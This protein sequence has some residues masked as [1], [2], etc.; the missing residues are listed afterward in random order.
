MAYICM[1][2]RVDG[3]LYG[4]VIQVGCALRNG[5]AEVFLFLRS[6]LLHQRLVVIYTARV[7]TNCLHGE[8]CFLGKL[9][10]C[11]LQ[12]ERD[13]FTD[14]SRHSSTLPLLDSNHDM[15]GTTLLCLGN[16]MLVL[17]PTARP[18]SLWRGH[19]KSP[20]LVWVLAQAL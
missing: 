7:W 9:F 18:E 20:L 17:Y 10:S 2:E 14:N 11:E 13:L 16:F 8:Q 4:Y 3:R 12:Q 6:D 19:S 5:R 15:A 1:R